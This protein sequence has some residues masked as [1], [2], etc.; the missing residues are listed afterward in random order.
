MTHFLI[1]LAAALAAQ[2]PA[3]DHTQMDHAA[4]QRAEAP[5]AAM[6]TD[7]DPKEPGQSAYAAMGEAVQILLADPNTDWSKVDVDTLRRHLVDM[8]NVT[9][10]AAVATTRIANGARFIVTGEPSVAQS[11]QRMTKSHFA[12]PDVGSGWTMKAESRSGGATVTVT[13]ADPAQAAK[14]AGLGFFGI[15]TMGAHHQPHHLMMARGGMKH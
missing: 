3:M 4:M 1:A 8:D 10:R 2:S 15:L 9:M 5:A 12:E 6:A 7:L 11:I 13:A 14:I